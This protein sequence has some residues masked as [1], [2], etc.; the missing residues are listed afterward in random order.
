MSYLR[1]FL[2]NKSCYNLSSEFLKNKSKNFIQPN[3]QQLNSEYIIPS[4][5]NSIFS[6]NYSYQ[7]FGD[8]ETTLRSNESNNNILH[9]KKQMLTNAIPLND[10]FK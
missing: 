8:I 5:R 1:R 2:S 7:T 9:F 6:D 10:E 4:P 3:L